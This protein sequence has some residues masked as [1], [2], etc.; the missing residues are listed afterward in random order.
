M[1]NCEK[2]DKCNHQTIAQFFNNSMNILWPD[3]VLHDNVLLFVS[4]AAPYIVKAG[5]ALNVFIPKMI[6]ITCLAHTFHRIA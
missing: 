6:H 3:V 4:D 1:L 5:K 2:L